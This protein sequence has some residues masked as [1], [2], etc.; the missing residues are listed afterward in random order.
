MDSLRYPVGKFS[1][2]APATPEKRADW[3]EA[4]R[5]APADLRAAVTGLNDTQLDTPYRE[6]GWTVRQVVHHIPDSHLNSYVRFRWTLTEDKPT[7]K[8]YDEKAWADLPDAKTAPVELSLALLGALH[9]RWVALLS[10][11]TEEEYARVFVHPAS[12]KEISLGRNLA[13]YAWHGQHHIAQLTSLR[14]RMDW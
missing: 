1:F 10:E 6:G 14:E 9:E 5:R 2:D 3:T 8:A 4:I 13:L 12:G 11:L 7:I